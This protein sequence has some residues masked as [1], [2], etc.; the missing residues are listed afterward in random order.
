MSLTYR[1]TSHGSSSKPTRSWTSK[2][3]DA[4]AINTYIK[5]GIDAY[6]YDGYDGV[7]GYP[8][9]LGTDLNWW[10]TEAF[11][12]YGLDPKKLPTTLDELYAQAITMA[13]K[14]HGTM[15]LISIAPALGDLAAQGVKVYKDGKFTFNTDQAVEII[16][17]YVE[18]Y[19]KKAMP[20]EVL[21][22]NYLG[23]SKLFLQGKVAWTTGSASFPVDLKKSAPKLLPH[24]AMTTR[25]GVPPLF[26][27]GICVSADSKNPNLAL[28]FAQ[29]V[30]N[31]ANQ[32]DFVKLAQG[33]LP[34]TKEAN[35]NTDS[36]TSV[37]SDPQMKKAAEA[38]ADEMKS[39]KIG[40]PMAYTD[41]MKAYVGQQISSVMQGDISAKDALDRAV[42]Y[43]ND[44]VTK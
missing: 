33:F 8:W 16:Q 2:K 20:P 10:N 42:K 43:C 14:S 22:N 6:T 7:Y 4:A 38:L 18:L 28:A 21:Q 25:I 26:V 24:V 34:G 19:A 3:A 44:H 32:V 27:Q 37:I 9:Y 1:R 30:T 29:Y 40:E 17:K 13:E 41:A 11:E 35:E 12:K 39:A 23:N 31:N 36:F 15:P 5:G